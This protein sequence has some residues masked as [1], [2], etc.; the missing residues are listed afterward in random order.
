MLAETLTFALL[1]QQSF[2][3]S[4]VATGMDREQPTA[5]VVRGAAE[6]DLATAYETAHREAVLSLRERYED[7]AEQLV[8]DIAPA[9]QPSLIT[10]KTV[11]R[12]L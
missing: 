6:L 2:T 4:W 7:R 10:D 5:T 3:P 9:W 11:R 12:W 1:I 8:G